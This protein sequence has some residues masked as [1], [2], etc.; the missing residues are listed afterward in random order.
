MPT[1]LVTG[2]TGFVGSHLVDRLLDRGWRVTAVLRPGSRP[3]WLD[4]R[5]FER[6]TVDFRGPFELPPADVVFHVAGVIR[7]DSYAA[8]LEGNRDLAR[9]VFEASRAGRFVHVSSLAAAGP[10]E[11]LDE[12]RPCAPISHYGR[13][14]WEGEREV[15]S[16]RER[17]PVTIVR[18]C[19]VYGP[20]DM[21]FLELFRTVARGVR[22][23][24]GGPKRIS[25]VHVADL[26][27][28]LIRAA[29]APEAANE[30]FYLAHPEPLAVSGFLDLVEEGLG[31]RG[32]RVAVPDRVVRFL[33]AVVEDGARWAGLR[34]V[35]GRDKALE[36][37]QPAWTCNPGKADRL[38]GWRARIDPAQGLRTTLA[39]YREHGLL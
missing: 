30:I 11:N 13:S 33:G 17:M 39:W 12:E 10:G 37:T 31:R 26:V 1:A 20:R 34:P 22:P 38:L 5:P 19:A 2:A 3:R 25:L 8:Y 15:W 27:E 7:A 4:G 24:V 21:A 29:E 36:M 23:E 18:P 32:L 16:R 14:K 35:F 9:R 28:G 6:L